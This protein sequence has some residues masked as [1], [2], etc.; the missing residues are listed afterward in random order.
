MAGIYTD[1]SE[2][3]IVGKK[4]EKL[5]VL[6]IDKSICQC[7]CD[8][9]VERSLPK[10]MLGK[11]KSCGCARRESN[12]DRTFNLQG[13]VFGR[14]TVVNQAEGYVNKW[15]CSCECGNDSIVSTSALRA[16]N[17]RSCGCLWQEAC[18][19]QVKKIAVSRRLAKG[20]PEDFQMSSFNRIER[21]KTRP[22]VRQI[23]NRDSF[24][25]AWC[26][27]Q[28]E[29]SVIEVH[30][31]VPWSISDELRFEKSNL[32]SLCGDC[33]L[34]IHKNNSRGPVD[35]IMTILLQGFANFQEEYFNREELNA[36]IL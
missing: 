32:V 4:F 12:K 1:F 7:V 25:C 16:G 31:L 18:K 2:E 36:C 30:H 35:E 24:C 5:T 14:L 21:E 33:H 34:K 9:G 20:F 3:S 11:T 13:Q 19:E 8:C 15:V 17:N 26:S 29:E 28:R 6:S 23:L 27:K 22:L 10:N